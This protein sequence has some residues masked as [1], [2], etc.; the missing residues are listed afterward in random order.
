MLEFATW[1]EYVTAQNKSGKQ[2]I[3][4]SK[5]ANEA[6]DKWKKAHGK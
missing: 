3:A 6:Y 4:G 5:E 1:D 2:L